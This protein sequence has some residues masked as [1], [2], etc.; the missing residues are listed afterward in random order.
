MQILAANN[1]LWSMFNMK[2]KIRDAKD[3]ISHL[4]TANHKAHEN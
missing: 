4:N 3:A 2:I 1:I